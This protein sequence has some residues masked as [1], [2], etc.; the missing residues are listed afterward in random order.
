MAVYKVRLR[1][2][3]SVLGL[4]LPG[5]RTLYGALCWGVRYLAGEAHLLG[6]LERFGEGTPP[7]LVT[8]LLPSDKGGD[9]LPCP[10]L[11]PL[12]RSVLARLAESI[13]S[14]LEELPRLKKELKKLEV[15]PEHARQDQHLL[16][17]VLA[18]QSK[19]WAGTS[20]L[21]RQDFDTFLEDRNEEALFMR[22]LAQDPSKSPPAG[23]PRVELHAS[24]DRLVNSTGGTGQLFFQQSTWPGRKSGEAEQEAWDGSCYFLLRSEEG[25]FRD[26]LLPALRLLEDLGIG[27]DRSVGR[28]RFTL[29]R[30]EAV[31]APWLEPRSQVC[32]IL[33]D[34]AVEPR[35]ALEDEASFYTLASRRPWSEWSRGPGNR[36][37]FL[38]PGSVLRVREQGYWYG[39]ALPYADGSRIRLLLL[40]FPAFFAPG[41]A[42]E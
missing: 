24:V 22:F 2:N 28:G 23:V 18:L 27:G 6:L 39:R 14:R 21:S 12:G 33:S 40:G 16:Q 1:L 35:L 36:F 13:V 26:T 25:L 42:S 29:T 4:S 19:K 34:T 8:G 7:F 10:R 5:S 38:A 32:T 31:D 15:S 41:G 3:S 37:L 17:Q 11:R 9:W 30:W 20:F